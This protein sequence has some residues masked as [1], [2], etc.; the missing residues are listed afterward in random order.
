MGYKKIKQKL[1]TGGHL[2]AKTW[3]LDHM[4]LECAIYGGLG[5][6]SL[7]N[8]GDQKSLVFFPSCSIFQAEKQL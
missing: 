3:F 2:F 7:V 5:S 8:I 6:L 4:K 1:L